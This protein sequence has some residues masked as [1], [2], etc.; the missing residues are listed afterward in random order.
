MKNIVLFY[1]S[2]ER[3]GATKILINLA[4]YFSKKKIN[5]YLIINKKI[6]NKKIKYIQLTNKN[7]FGRTRLISGIDGSLKL[8]KILL[9]LKRKETKILSLQSN[10]FSVLV[11][12]FLNFKIGIRVSEDPCS[13]TKFADNKLKAYLV[14]LSKLITYNL[15]N[16]IIVNSKKSLQCTKKFC[17]NKQKVNLLY[18]PSL[19]KIKKFKIRKNNKKILSIGRFC[20]QKNQE[21]IIK[22]FARFSYKRSGYTLTLCGDGPDSSKIKKLITDLKMG[23]KIKLIPWKNNLEKIYNNNSI[24][25]LTSLYEGMP[26]VII[27]AIN[28]NIPCISTN[29]SGV[30]DLLLNGKG[31]TIIKNNNVSDLYKAFLDLTSNYNIISKKVIL[32]KK[33]LNRF[34]LNNASL[35]YMKFLKK[36]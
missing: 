12:F 25:V 23:S 18:N 3:G 17:F 31:G 21:L 33:Y 19:K 32:A 4:D 35:K 8:I 27:E 1:P 10:F 11:A 2:Y 6:N 14:M 13:A 29:V 5:I 16:K 36:L 24:F 26:N 20:K 34:E 22:A 30:S 9:K 28:Y 15:S 7:K